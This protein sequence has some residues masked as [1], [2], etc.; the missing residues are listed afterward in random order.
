MHTHICRYLSENQIEVFE[1]NTFSGHTFEVLDL[2]HNR[3]RSFPY[4][5][6]RAFPR[7]VQLNN[8]PIGN[9]PNDAF[10]EVN[11]KYQV[12]SIQELYVSL[13]TWQVLLIFGSESLYE[14]LNIQL[15]Q[16]TVI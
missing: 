14:V 2:R 5:I 1:E 7:K 8:N 10:V 3:L 11:N 16:Q 4:A 6:K 13:D 15:T 9:L 12:R